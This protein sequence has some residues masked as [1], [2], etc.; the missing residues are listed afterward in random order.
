[1]SKVKKYTKI[2]VKGLAYTDAS[3]GG[4]ASYKNE[5]YLFKGLEKGLKL[6]EEQEKLLE[7]LG[8]TPNL[9]KELEKSESSTNKASGSSSSVGEVTGGEL[10]IHKTE[11]ETEID[12]NMSE[13]LLKELE[14]VK[15][16]LAVSEAKGSIAEFNFEGEVAT[17][18]AKAIASLKEDEDKEAICKALT[19]LKNV[20]EEA[21]ENLT[22]A[23]NKTDE[24]PLQKE[25]SNEAGH[26]EEEPPTLSKAQQ[27][28]KA[29]AEKNK[30]NK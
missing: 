29:I 19:V 6:N 1:M 18:L 3:A 23:T 11:K 22:K 14:A 7:K 21:K 26:E 15:H 16:K 28:A 13:E 9:K 24:N 5:A 17:G 4:A 27:V 30:E 20:A 10:E 8:E 12:T 2:T 25:L